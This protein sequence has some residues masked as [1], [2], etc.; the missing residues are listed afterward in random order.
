MTKTP[1]RL[2]TACLLCAAGAAYAAPYPN[3][4]IR[5]IVPFA[6]GGGTD[7]VARILA[8]ELAKELD[9]TIV[10]ENKPGA[11]GIIGTKAAL[12]APADGQTIVLAIEATIAMS[13]WLYKST[14]YSYK[15]FAGISQVSSQP[16]LLVANPAVQADSL[17]A[18]SDLSQ[19]EAGELNYATGASA[20]FLAGETLKAAT[21]LDMLN[22]PYKGSGEAISDV[23][24]GRVQLM[25]SSPVSVLPH[26]QQG[27]LKPI[28]VTSRERYRLLPDLPSVAEQGYPGFDV[29][30]WYGLAAP[31]GTPPEI[32]RTLHAATQNA[33]ESPELKTQFQ[34]AGVEPKGSSS[35]DF[36]AL[37]QSETQ[38]WEQPI[39]DAGL[40]Q[41]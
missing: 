25:I 24:G 23:V 33:L 11:N 36:D 39:K 21:Q 41:K 2:L 32:I 15:D 28:A 40:F 6:P 10:V 14:G 35:A 20:A 1:L 13:P 17:K 37:M 30:G 38:R 12:Q 19:K 22:I 7:V 31:A 9:A 5:F 16:Y 3:G 34:T 8:K 4:P 27:Q 18:L 29:V 26:L